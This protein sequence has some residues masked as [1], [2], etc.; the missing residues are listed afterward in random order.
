MTNVEPITGSTLAT[1]NATYVSV[2]EDGDL[3]KMTEAK[4]NKSRADAIKANA[5][6]NA[7]NVA[8][9]PGTEV[10]ANV[11]VPEIAKQQTYLKHEAGTLEDAQALVPDKKVFLVYWNRGYSLGEESVISDQMT[12]PA[13][14]PVEGVIDLQ[15]ELATIKERARARKPLSAE[16]T[17]NNLRSLKASGAL[18]QEQLQAIVAEFMEALK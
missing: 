9:A 15:P 17:I 13:F 5:E 10:R 3:R 7:A 12:D 1:R 8:A 4:F 14:S 16:D 6:I 2:L 18:T 11:V